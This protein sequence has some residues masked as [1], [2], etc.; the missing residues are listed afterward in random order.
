LRKEKSKIK[1]RGRSKKK[2]ERHWKK[3]LGKKSRAKNAPV[4][5]REFPRIWKK[6]RPFSTPY[7]L[8]TRGEIKA[9]VHY[10]SKGK[11]TGVE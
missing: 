7:A 2:K 9:G 10:N 6:G 5:E 11:K 4:N 8:I 1:R 3:G